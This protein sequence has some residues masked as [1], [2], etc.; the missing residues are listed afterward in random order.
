MPG[1][2]DGEE[3]AAGRPFQEA[4]RLLASDCSGTEWERMA[5]QHFT[6]QALLLRGD[7]DAARRLATQRLDEARRRNDV[8]A[9]GVFQTTMRAWHWVLE[10]EPEQAWVEVDEA[11]SGWPS[12]EYYL[13]HQFRDMARAA[14][15]LYQGSDGEAL[16]LLRT[17]GRQMRKAML[18]AMPALDAEYLSWL[19]RA[20]IRA[21]DA[22]ALKVVRRRLRRSRLRISAGYLAGLHAL[23]AGR[24]GDSAAV[25]RHL[26]RAIE[27]GDETEFHLFGAGYRYRLGQQTG[28]RPGSASSAKPS[29]GSG[30]RA[31]RTPIGSWT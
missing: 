31:R 15:F 22:A 7:V 29:T 2:H 6:T 4:E 9:L 18:T 13:V 24:R 14:L 21:G 17:V 10:N 27:I 30:D 26:A 8:F 11:L 19:G 28:V 23:D 12:S 1:G 3:P 20:A 16:A 25:Q 5:A